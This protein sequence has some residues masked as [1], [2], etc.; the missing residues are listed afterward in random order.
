MLKS[1]GTEIMEYDREDITVKMINKFV[2]LKNKVIL[3]I[4]C[5]DGKVSALLAVN[6]KKYI[7]IDPDSKSIEKAIS[8]FNT[9]DFRIGFGEALDFDNDTFDVVLFTLSLHHQDSRK[10]LKEAHRVLKRKGNLLITEPSVD[11]ELQQFFNLFQD[12]TNRIKL[13]YKNLTE[14]QFRLEKV[15]SFCVKA[16]FEDQTDLC[17]Y[18]FDREVVSPDDSVRIVEK[19]NQL[20]PTRIKDRPILLHDIINVYCLEK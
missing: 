8:L 3:E 6:T 17:N 19:L 16:K 10:A 9:V 4:G 5:G 7:G 18:H 2:N 14:S 13:A 20:L 11:G 15:E 1:Y 12:E